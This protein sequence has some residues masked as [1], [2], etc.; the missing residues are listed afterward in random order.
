MNFIFLILAIPF[1][2]GFLYIG[3]VALVAI[4]FYKDSETDKAQLEYL[5]EKERKERRKQIGN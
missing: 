5:I 4:F 1:I 3:F 2:L